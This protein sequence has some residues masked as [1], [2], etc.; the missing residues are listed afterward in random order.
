MWSWI[1][2]QNVDV[3]GNENAIPVSTGFAWKRGAGGAK[4][5]REGGPGG[6]MTQTMHTHV[7]K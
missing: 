2:S 7:N 3:E 6:K 5:V 4:R 1:V